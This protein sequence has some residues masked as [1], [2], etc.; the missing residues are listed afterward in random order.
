MK[1][2]ASSYA[3]HLTTDHIDRIISPS[4]LLNILK[5]LKKSREITINAEGRQAMQA[6]FDSSIHKTIH[7]TRTMKCLEYE[8][9]QGARLDF[10]QDEMA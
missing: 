10:L 6:P 2:G 1:I 5:C 3:L 9:A 4:L 7:T 8:S